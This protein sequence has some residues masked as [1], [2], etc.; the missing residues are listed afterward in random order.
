WQHI[1][2]FLVIVGIA[3]LVFFVLSAVAGDTWMKFA[4]KYGWNT[5]VMKWLDS[6]IFSI[7]IVASILEL[8]RYKEQYVWWLITDVIAVAQYAIKRDPVYTTKKT[9]YLIEAFVGFRNWHRLSKRNK[10]NE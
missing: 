2:V 7:G 8:M 5:T 1:V 4:V 6:A 10:T 9:I 3:V